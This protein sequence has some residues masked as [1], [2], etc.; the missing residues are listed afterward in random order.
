MFNTE[1]GDYFPV[2]WGHNLSYR[3]SGAFTAEPPGENLV[4]VLEQQ[5]PMAR[6]QI[7]FE[8]PCRAPGRRGRVAVQARG[9]ASQE[10]SVV[11]P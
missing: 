7:V 8:R 6:L 11:L 3:K 1:R 10:Q 5:L 2:T 9:P 4:V